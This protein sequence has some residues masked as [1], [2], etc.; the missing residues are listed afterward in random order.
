MSGLNHAQKKLR[1]IG[2][3]LSIK[4]PTMVDICVGMIYNSTN[5][6]TSHMSIVK[7]TNRKTGVVTW[8]E[9][10]SHY[11]PDTKQSRPIRKYLGKEDPVTGELIPSSGKRGRKSGSQVQDSG[12][13]TGGPASAQDGRIQQMEKQS[14]DQQERIR[15]LEA[16]NRQLHDTICRLGS[17]IE[18]LYSLYTSS[19]D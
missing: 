10:T 8:Y 4:V 12:H 3:Y 1:I 14:R 7:Y 17:A 5:R 11:D 16:E 18:K 13:H 2:T 15:T 9:S 19:D 6:R